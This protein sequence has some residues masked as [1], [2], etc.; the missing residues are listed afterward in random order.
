MAAVACFPGLVDHMVLLPQRCRIGDLPFLIEDADLLNSGLGRHGS[1]RA[2]ETFP[3][4][5]QHV[6]GGAMLD[7]VADPFRAQKG[8][9]LQMPA[10]QPHIQI[11]EEAEDYDHRPQQK[12]VQLDAERFCDLQPAKSG[13]FSLPH[14]PAPPRLEWQPPRPSPA[15]GSGVPEGKSADTSPPIRRQ[16]SR[17][18]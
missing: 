6:I 9:L 5:A 10:V 8:V 1:Y 4:I 13:W 7:D 12:N 14:V 17:C 11:A 16:R 18:R 15:R 3:I 2:V